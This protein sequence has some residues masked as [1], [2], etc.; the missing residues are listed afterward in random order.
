MSSNS[1]GRARTITRVLLAMVFAA[2]FF[3]PRL[4]ARAADPTP[5]APSRVTFPSTTPGLELTGMLYRSSSSAP[6][7]AIAIISGTSGTEGFQN[8]EMP[9][10][11]RRR[12][13]GNST[14]ERM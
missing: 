5:L 9:W 2:Q 8:W 7:P 4:P 12:A 11:Q 14:R 1:T 3:T 13:H 6:A 10:A